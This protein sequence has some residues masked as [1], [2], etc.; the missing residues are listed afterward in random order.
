VA[1]GTSVQGPTSRSPRTLFR[2]AK[3]DSQPTQASAVLVATIGLPIPAA[4][5]AHAVD[6]SGGRPVAVVTIA[7]MYGSSF[8][9]PNPGLLP[10]RKEMDEQ[11]SIVALAMKR[12]ERRGVEAWGQV[13]TTRRFGRTIAQVACVRSVDHVLVVTA[14]VPRWRQ[15]I[16]GD[17]TRELKRRLG[18]T[19][20]VEGFTV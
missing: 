4:V 8:G 11:R 16:E 10:T 19:I 13:A 1:T 14:Q 17:M 9:L 6:L 3:W 15:V 5:I 12:L 2:R 7:R 20:E 18:K